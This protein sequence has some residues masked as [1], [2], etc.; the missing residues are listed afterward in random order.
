MNGFCR[1]RVVRLAFG[2]FDSA[3]GQ[4]RAHTVIARL[5]VDVLVVVGDRVEGDE[6]L[7]GALRAL[8]EIRVEHLLPR[9]GVHLGR[10]REDAVEIEEAGADPARQANSLGLVEHGQTLTV[11]KTK[12]RPEA[13]LCSPSRSRFRPPFSLTFGFRLRP[14]GSASSYLRSVL[15]AR[16]NLGARRSRHKGSLKQKCRNLDARRLPA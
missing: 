9:G 7:A 5:A 14:S 16:G 3:G 12:E 2:Q 4:E 15:G 1:G 11:T 10:L 6:L 8:L 13:L